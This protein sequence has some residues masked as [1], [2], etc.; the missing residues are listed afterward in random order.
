VNDLGTKSVDE[1]P[2]A[3]ETARLRL[4]VLLP[5]EIEAL[6][7]GDTTRA[8]QLAEVTFPVGWPDD[9]EARQ[10][11]TWH[12]RHLRADVAPRPWRIRVIVE[13]ATNVVVGSVNMKGPPDA[14]GDVEIG[15]G[16]NEDRRRRGYAFE[17]TAAV[18]GWA[19]SQPGVH[20]FSAT[21]PDDN[22]SSQALARKLGMARTRELRR[23]LPLWVRPAA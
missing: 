13:Q 21:I 8:S 17:A 9:V 23:E 22:V 11:L 3:I 2:P 19:A 16:V 7:E 20:R 10:G 1:R 5:K 14:R 12:L 18:M 4:L 6:I 15:W